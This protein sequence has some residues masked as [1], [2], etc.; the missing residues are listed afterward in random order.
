MSFEL[1]KRDYEP[2]PHKSQSFNHW[3]GRCMAAIESHLSDMDDDVDAL[4]A[5]QCGD[6]P[7]PAEFAPEEGKPRFATSGF[8]TECHPWENFVWKPSSLPIHTFPEG[9]H[10]VA[11]T[12]MEPKQHA[13]YPIGSQDRLFIATNCNIY[14]LIDGK[15]HKVLLAN[16]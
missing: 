7:S 12:K 2:T 13:L 11:M 8:Q 16:A 1:P 14:E 9:E 4:W 15:L 5:V 3:L 6:V 10:V